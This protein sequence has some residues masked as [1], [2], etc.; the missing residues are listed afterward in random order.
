[1]T[2]MAKVTERQ[3]GTS[4]PRGQQRISS[5]MRLGHLGFW[6]ND[7]ISDWRM[8]TRAHNR[9]REI[10]RERERREERGRGRRKEKE[11]W[12]ER[13]RDRD[14]ERER[15][16]QRGREKETEWDHRETERERER[17]REREKH[18]QGNGI[19]APRKELQS[20]SEVIVQ[21]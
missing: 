15:Q 18:L 6:N 11:G 14:T 17:E 8:N 1:M 3:A 5:R 9:E 19:E 4:G 7:D 12:R 10:E 21:S 2:D 16:R 20:H 13:L